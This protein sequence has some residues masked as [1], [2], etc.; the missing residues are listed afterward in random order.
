MLS[1]T[2][3]RSE[4]NKI[5]DTVSKFP[6]SDKFVITQTNYGMDIGVQTTTNG[7]E[8]TLVV[9]VVDYTDW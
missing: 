2:M 9:P 8:G 6:Y 4:M 1:I 7:I 5:I 3:S